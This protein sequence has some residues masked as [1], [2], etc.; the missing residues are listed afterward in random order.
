[1]LAPHRYDMMWHRAIKYCM[2]MKLEERKVCICQPCPRP[3]AKFLSECW[4]VVWSSFLVLDTN[5][6]LLT[7]CVLHNETD[8]VS[9]RLIS[10]V[11]YVSC[12]A[13][14]ACKTRVIVSCVWLRFFLTLLSILAFSP[15]W[16]QQFGILRDPAVGPDQFRVR[17]DLKTH[18]FEWH[19]VS[20][21]A[22][23]VFSRNVLYKSTF[24]LL[25]AVNEKCRVILTVM[26]LLLHDTPVSALTSGCTDMKKCT[27]HC[28]LLN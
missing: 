27:V 1:M 25:T 4:Y 8:T 15:L 7:D 11:N 3:S 20:F 18:L 21:S 14:R 5:D 23:A 10:C 17:R 28:I 6:V 2:L 24:Y 19:C 13:L 16:T 9:A 12:C 26:L 22:L